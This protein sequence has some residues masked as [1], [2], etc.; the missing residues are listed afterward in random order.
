MDKRLETKINK[1]TE[2]M[3]LITRELWAKRELLLDQQSGADKDNR[4]NKEEFIAY[5]NM[6]INPDIVHLIKAHGL[7]NEIDSFLWQCVLNG[8]PFTRE[9]IVALVF[10]NFNVGSKNMRA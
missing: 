7:L 2:K 8:K 5:P 1:R 9:T 3:R 4:Y 6:H 10:D